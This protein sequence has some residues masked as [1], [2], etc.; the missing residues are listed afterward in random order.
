M[1]DD[2]GDAMGAAA[3]TRCRSSGGAKALSGTGGVRGTRKLG[4]SRF[5]RYRLCRA[6]ISPVRLGRS[7]GPPLHGR[8]PPRPVNIVLLDPGGFTPPYDGALANALA[9][10]G[11]DVTVLSTRSGL[12]ACHPPV[13][14]LEVFPDSV[15]RRRGVFRQA[16]LLLKG[17][18][19]LRALK[20]AERVIREIQPDVIHWQW[21]PLPVADRWMVHRLAAVAPQV[22]TVHDATVFNGT[23]SSRLQA[24][25]YSAA[26]R[27]MNHLIV[28]SAHGRDRLLAAY[29]IDPAILHIVPHGA[30]THYG[31]LASPSG[32][33]MQS[34]VLPGT[35]KPYKGI[36]VLLE[37]FARLSPTER[38]GWVVRVVG[39]PG[40]DTTSLGKMVRT[41]G[42]TAQ[43]HFDFRR[44][45][46]TEFADEIAQAG[47]IVLPYTEIDQSGV[48]MA[49]MALGRPIIASAIGAIPE[50]VEHRISAQLVPAN[51][52]GSLASALAE[53]MQSP[54]RRRRMGDAA[55][56]R[57]ERHLAWPKIAM[58][59]RLVYE[60]AV[61]LRSGQRQEH[62][63]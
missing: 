25:G 14:A 37:A 21:L 58:S 31:D 20:R 26:I 63:A 7:L 48:L 9:A 1:P 27:S 29:S 23:G 61:A 18:R 44:L 8:P 3:G 11:H 36:P 38:N 30:F 60:G 19:Y 50:T 4:N 59:T 49:A 2:P 5:V 6:G 32:T 40:M 54:E 41:L 28:H 51:D 35:I 55:R 39:H 53:L 62:A 33:P 56:L 34:L 22:L 52:V 13:R 46:E 12:A 17:I 47:V 10:Q 45:S 57:A 24:V 15:N 43:V 16:A 42:L